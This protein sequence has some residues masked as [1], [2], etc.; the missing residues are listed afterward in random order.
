[1]PE[2][3]AYPNET[4][5]LLL[6]RASC[7]TFQDKSVPPDTLEWVLAAGVHAPTGGNLQ[8]F[9]IIKTEQKPVAAKLAELCGRQMF[10]AQ[11]PVNLLFCI[12]QHRLNRWAEISV[13]P[14]TA[15]RSFRHF[16]IAFQDT[17]IAAQNIC[18]AADAVGLGSVYIGTVLECFR[19]LK[20]MFRLPSGVMPVVLLSLGY[21]TR[22]PSPRSK[23]PVGVIVHDEVYT[24]LTD[25]ELAAVYDRKY[26]SPKIE[27]TDERLAEIER[28][29]RRTTGSEFAGQCLASIEE[30][31]YINMAQRYFGLHYQADEMPT[32]NEEFVSL[33]KE[34]G[35]NCFERWDPVEE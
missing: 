21:P 18:T 20:E 4:I 30:A 12:D 13:A 11:A 1:M 15:H 33:M 32:G 29:C 14:F 35:I 26:D 27:V 6:E 7:R 16:W 23:L 31:G 25:Q 24:D 5:R 2:N 3:R 34:F 28:V 17:I 8:P 22:Q 19:E 10:I 9:S